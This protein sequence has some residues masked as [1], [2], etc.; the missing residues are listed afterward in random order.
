M[1]VPLPRVGIPIGY[2]PAGKAV[3]LNPEFQRFFDALSRTL[4]SGG[5]G[6]T[7]TIDGH[8]IQDEG[9][10]LTQRATM[11]FVGDGVEVTDA[12]GK[13]VVTISGASADP[14]YGYFPSW[15]TAAEGQY[16]PRGW[17]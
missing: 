14:T 8:V 13:T 7:A 15:G 10:T 1:T 5:G 3:R 4:A 9:A 2:D 6:G 16:F 12:G 11:N 17:T